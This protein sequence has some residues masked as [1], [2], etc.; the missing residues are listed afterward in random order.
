MLLKDAFATYCKVLND[1]IGTV[2]EYM[3]AMQKE[4]GPL[5]P[6]QAQALRLRFTTNTKDDYDPATPTALLHPEVMHQDISQQQPFYNMLHE[7]YLRN[8]MPALDSYRLDYIRAQ[9]PKYADKEDCQILADLLIWSTFD[10]TT[11]LRQKQQDYLNKQK[12]AKDKA[13]QQMVQAGKTQVRT[14]AT[15][16]ALLAH[17]LETSFRRVK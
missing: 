7:I 1:N 16:P 15:N 10:Q 9:N 11:Y 13:R 6:L 12:Q 2:I 5:F 8:L 3:L 4:H 14:I 17:F